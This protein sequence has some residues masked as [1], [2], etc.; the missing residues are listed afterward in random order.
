MVTHIPPPKELIFWKDIYV[1]GH[2]AKRMDKCGVKATNA[3]SQKS[4]R[5]YLEGGTCT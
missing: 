5:S 2:A 3:M 1:N 4:G